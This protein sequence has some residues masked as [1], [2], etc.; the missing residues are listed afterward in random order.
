M[1]VAEEEEN[2][3]TTWGTTGKVIE[4]VGRSAYT[5]PQ[6]HHIICAIHIMEAV[7][8]KELAF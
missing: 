5:I 7:F 4:F 8:C 2:L 1:R 6:F 3:G